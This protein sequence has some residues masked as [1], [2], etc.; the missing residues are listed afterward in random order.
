MLKQYKVALALTD[1]EQFP[2]GLS[3]SLMDRP[4]TDFAYVRW[5]GKREI[6]DF[7]H[8]QIDRT[9]AVKEWLEQFKVFDKKVKTILGF[10]TNHFQ[11]HSPY[12]AVKFR[13]GLGLKPIKT[14]KV[15]GQKSL[16]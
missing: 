15:A 14:K 16:F 11:G 8:M 6:T 13:E 4:T 7:S 2:R 12:S 1:S 5:L 9:E 10:F 3:F